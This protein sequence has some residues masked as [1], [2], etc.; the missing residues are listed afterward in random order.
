MRLHIHV[1][2]V[3]CGA[4]ADCVLTPA[5]GCAASLFLQ[6]MPRAIALHCAFDTEAQ[7]RASSNFLLPR[8]AWSALRPSALSSAALSQTTSAF[9]PA[10]ADVTSFLNQ[11]IAWNRQSP[12]ELQLASGS[13]NPLTVTDSRH[14]LD[15]I[16]QFD[17]ESAPYAVTLIARTE[18]TNPVGIATYLST[19]ARA[20]GDETTDGSPGHPGRIG[21]R[22]TSADDRERTAQLRCHPRSWSCRERSICSGEDR[23]ARNMMQFLIRT[24]TAARVAWLVR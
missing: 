1:Y 19:R 11:T 5:G 10:P 18:P 21:V 7:L 2:S 9:L 22:S 4:T 23:V 15:Q 8:A 6:F 24:V 16:V 14:N 12:V 17:F 20:V 3:S 13:T